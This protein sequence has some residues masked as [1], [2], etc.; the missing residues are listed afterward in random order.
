MQFS[1]NKP[2]Y[3]QIADS[4]SDKILREELAAED[5]IPS[6]REY[7]AEI[8]VNPNTL[9]H[10]YEYLSKEGIIHSKRGLGYY[11]SGKAR[12]IILNLG[13]TQ[14]FEKELPRLLERMLLLE[15]PT[16]Q[17]MNAISMYQSLHSSGRL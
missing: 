17:V 2:I 5:R 16:E 15:I 10:T 12:E 3:L 7:A 1:D 13:R 6:V 14:F 9:M 4:I 8:G 11:V